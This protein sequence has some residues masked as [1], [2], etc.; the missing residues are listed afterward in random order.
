[1][2]RS[3]LYAPDMRAAL[4]HGEG[5]VLMAMPPNPATEGKSLAVP[6]SMFSRHLDSGQT[7]SLMTGIVYSTGEDRMMAIRTIDPQGVGMDKP[8]VL[9][10]SREMGGLLA[11]WRSTVLIYSQGYV[12]L[13]LLLLL[14]VYLLQRKQLALL[15]LTHDRD[16]E[17]KKHAQ[18]MDL[19]LAGGD[20]GLWDVDLVTGKREVNARAQEII[21]LGPNDPVDNE[22]GWRARVHPEDVPAWL[23]ASARHDAGQVEAFVIDYR[24][25]HRDGYWVWIHSRGKVTQRDAAG[26]ATRVTGTYQDV[27]EG[28]LAQ[29]Q[30]ADFA[31]RDP[32]TQLPNRR[33]LMDRLNQARLAS[34][35]SRTLGALLLLDLDHFKW[36]NDNLGHDMGD[37]LLQ[38]LAARL[39]TCVRMTD[40]VA[41]LGGDEF[42]VLISDLGESVQEAE[43]R[44]RA[45]AEKIEEALLPP[46]L[47]DGHTHTTSVSVG[48][49]IFNGVNQ[50]IDSLFKEADQAMYAAKRSRKG[51]G[52][53]LETV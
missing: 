30:I 6:G 38:Q 46:F 44:A 40:T 47:L 53:A 35:R 13:A 16:K 12:L 36:V 22:A 50:V 43:N 1:M 48:F 27:T 25:Q 45:M 4:A 11:P 19:A 5:K 37:L 41:R 2:L 21:G 15:A 39:L 49:A 34:A 28:K 20:L 29:E 17:A 31:F 23:A 26:L 51:A 32:L 14:I 10:V 7:E 18:R 8:L 42:V 24:V 52:T 3:V 9:A 33:L